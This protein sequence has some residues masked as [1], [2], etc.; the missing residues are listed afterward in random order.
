MAG[1]A[2][3]ETDALGLFGR[4]QQAP[5]RFDFYQAMRRLECAYPNEPR[6]GDSLHSKRDKIRLGQDPTMAFQPSTLASFKQGKSGLP[7]RLG[8]Y[9]F[10]LFGPNGPLPLHLT[11]YVHDRVHN[12]HDNTQVGFLDHFHHRLLTLFYRVWANSQPSVSFDRPGDDRFGNYLGTVFGIGSPHLRDRDAMPDL[13]KLHYAGRL[14]DHNHNAEGLEAILEDFFHLPVRIEEFIGTWIDLPDNSRCRLGES[15]DISSLGMTIIL[16]DR[17][18]QG[19]QKFRIVMGAVDFAD[20]QRMLPGGESLKRL[21]AIVKNYI[22]DELDWELNLILQEQEVPPLS[23]DGESRL[24][25][26]TWLA[27]QPLGRDG[28]DLFLHPLEIRGLER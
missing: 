14:A 16:G 15:T 24:G 26:T 1:K 28:D 3:S 18:W 4:L 10:G 8:V 5:Y 12:E 23:L 21:I 9:F 2:G 13:A 6:L 11:E 7:P 25:W 20:Y 27:Q 22:G 17:V 19:Q